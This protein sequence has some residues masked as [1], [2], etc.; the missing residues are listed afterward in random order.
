M[1]RL[2]CCSFA[3]LFGFANFSTLASEIDILK[4]LVDE[5][6]VAERLTTNMSLSF[7][8]HAESKV[9]LI[10]RIG[11]SNHFLVS[12]DGKPFITDATGSFLFGQ[13]ELKRFTP[14]GVFNAMTDNEGN[15][16]NVDFYS[17]VMT[18]KS[19]LPLYKNTRGEEKGTIVAFMDPSCPNCQ[20][21][22]AVQRISVTSSGYDVVYVPS[23][24]NPNDKKLTNVLV[25]YYCGSE[26]V[27]GNIQSLY[28]NYKKADKNPP[29]KCSAQQ[30]S[31]TKNL[32]KVFSRHRMIG[33]PAFITCLLYTSDAADE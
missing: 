33:S 14:K 10:D 23:A 4:E 15:Q 7:G 12:L 16:S 8:E 29:N 22:H 2:F 5:D 13:S 24:R 11:V 32:I 30:K 6:V 31:Y 17:Y 28:N 9:K 18:Q 21:F 25:N 26:V 20:K 1:F 3:L 19:S 27:I